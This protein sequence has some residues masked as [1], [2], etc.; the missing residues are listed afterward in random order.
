MKP[1]E[2][3]MIVDKSGSMQ[4]LVNDVVGGFNRFVDEQK[5]VPGD[6][7]LTLVQFDTGYA[8]TID[9]AALQSIAP[10]TAA[11][12]VPGGGT[13]LLDAVGK[14]VTALRDRTEKSD[15]AIVCIMTDGQE[16]SSHEYTKSAIKALIESM[17]AER[18][19]EFS[20]VGANQDAFAEAGALGISQGTTA[21]FAANAAGMRGATATLSAYTTNYRAGQNSVKTP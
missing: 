3:V 2:I 19:W 9:K 20:F 21:N 8:V 4:S 17:R 12:Y 6:A 13:A 16:N 5:A 7:V 18:G 11:N 15:K 1:V 14:A 10:L